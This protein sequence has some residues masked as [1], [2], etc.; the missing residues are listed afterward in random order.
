MGFLRAI[1]KKFDFTLESQNEKSRKNFFVLGEHFHL[2]QRLQSSSSYFTFR[3]IIIII[4]IIINII[5]VS[6]KIA[7]SH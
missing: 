6:N 5:Y 1:Q 7:V 3:L 4:I 2:L